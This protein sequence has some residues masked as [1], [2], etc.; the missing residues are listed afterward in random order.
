MTNIE[1]ALDAIKKGRFIIVYDALGREEECDFFLSAQSC[2]KEHI[3]IMR[4][5]GGGLIF[6][7]IPPK[8][9]NKL[10]LPYLSDLNKEL[11]KKH[12][13]LKKLVPNDIP[14]DTKSSFS[15]TINHRK[16]FTGITDIDRALT[17]SAFGKLAPIILEKSKIEAQNLIGENF[18]TPGHAPLCLASDE[19]LKDRFGH[20]EL[21]CAL[22]LMAGLNGVMAGCEI[23]D[24]SGVAMPKT[25]VQEYA[26]K[27]NIPF[28]EGKEIIEEWNKSKN[29]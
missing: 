23:M 10:A 6:L 17:I 28:L 16:T 5:A 8:I 1:K 14:Y 25:K 21:G 24:D 20:T 19:I 27:N 2:A 15:L 26:L 13:I 9:K 29:F 7:M 12:K 22:S 11:E 18:R 4:Q 3:K